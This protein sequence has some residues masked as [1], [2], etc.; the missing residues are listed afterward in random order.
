[1][2]KNR[3][4]FYFDN[5]TSKEVRAGGVLFYRLNGQYEFLM[6]N[7]RNNFEDFGGCTDLCDKDIIDTICREVDEESNGVITS[8][9]VRESIITETPLYIKHCKYVLYIVQITADYDTKSFGNKELHDNIDRTVH[10][11]KADNFENNDFI[12]KLN[13]RLRMFNVL[14]YIKTIIKLD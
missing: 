11:I 4:T 6:I 9:F 14:S 5:D 10:W 13:F 1:M 7:S 12:K 3:P 8:N 2:N